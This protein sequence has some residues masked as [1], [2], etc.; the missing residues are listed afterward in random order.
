MDFFEISL[1]EYCFR[2]CRLG[3]S[4]RRKERSCIQGSRIYSLEQRREI[5]A[6]QKEGQLG[7]ETKRK[8]DN[9]RASHTSLCILSTCLTCLVKH[10]AFSRHAME[11]LLLSLPLLLLGPMDG[12]KRAC[13]R[14]PDSFTF[15]DRY[16]LSRVD[17]AFLFYLLGQKASEVYVCFRRYCCL[18]EF[19]FCLHLL[20]VG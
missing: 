3:P 18:F 19:R 16:S 7:G 9:L 2:K 5:N 11:R 6:G 17:V 10:H 15:G 13:R 12:R 4:I 8:H 20:V 1:S 14:I